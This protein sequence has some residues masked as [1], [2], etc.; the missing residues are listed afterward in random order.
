MHRQI[1]NDALYSDKVTLDG[2]AV[3]DAFTLLHNVPVSESSDDMMVE[4]SP[5]L[6]GTIFEAR[7]PWKTIHNI[8]VLIAVI[9]TTA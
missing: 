1:S 2:S 7:G 5:D 8:K 3:L 9:Y 6:I 4:R